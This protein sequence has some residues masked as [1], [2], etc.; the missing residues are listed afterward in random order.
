[1]VDKWY[2]ISP[3]VEYSGNFNFFLNNQIFVVKRGFHYSFCSRLE[4]KNFLNVDSGKLNSDEKLN[5][6]KMIDHIRKIHT[7]IF[8]GKY[9]LGQIVN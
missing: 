8:A 5:E 3:E 1:M 9:G 4:S 2:Q 7:D 6:E